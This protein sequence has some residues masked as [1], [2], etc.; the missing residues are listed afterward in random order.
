MKTLGLVCVAV[1][2]CLFA[3]SSASAQMGRTRGG[4]MFGSPGLSGLWH[5][6]VGTA[7]YY[8]VQKVGRPVEPFNFAVIGKETVQGKNAVWVEFTMGGERMGNVL[9][10]ELVL[11]DPV[12]MQIQTFKGV[13]QM[14]GRP[15]M[16]IPEEMLHQQQPLQFKDARADSVDLGSQ[17]VTTPAGTFSCEHYRE[18]DG[19]SEFWVSEKVVPI[20][21]VKS[22]EKDGQTTILVKTV[23]DAK[24]QITGAVQPFNPMM[25]MPPDSQQ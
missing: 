18:K 11:F 19:S 2:L 24:D 6:V 15:P 17:S 8:S 21:L 22:V 16:E 23:T 13:V 20:G 4:G 25:F 3:A 14:P 7:A 10:K 12:S 1:I 9:A 5:P